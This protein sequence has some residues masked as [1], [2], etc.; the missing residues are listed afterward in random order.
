MGVDFDV[1]SVLNAYWHQRFGQ[2]SLGGVS[3]L[4][5]IRAQRLLASKVWA[6]YW[7]LIPPS[8]LVCAQRLLASKVWAVLDLI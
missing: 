4:G 2:V 5:T 7:R 8:S 6:D 1:E 3:L